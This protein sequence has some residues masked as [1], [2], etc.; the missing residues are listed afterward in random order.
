M[1]ANINSTHTKKWCLNLK[2]NGVFI[3]LFSLTS[4]GDSDDWYLNLDYTFYPQRKP[5]KLDYFKLYFELKKAIKLFN[6][7]ILHSH[8]ATNYSFM[9]AISGFK[10][11]ILTTW[12][13]DVFVYPKKN[14]LFKLLLEFNLY[15]A[16]LVISTSHIMAVELANY[17][18][19][20]IEVI[21]F[22]VDFSLYQ[23]KK[24]SPLSIKT[25]IVLGCFKKTESIYGTDVLIKALSLVKKNITDK[26]IKLMIVGDGKNLEEYKQL[27]VNL[28]L[29][30]DVSFLGWR[31][32]K[33]VPELLS[34]IDICVYLSRNESFGVSLIESMACKI[35]IVASKAPG[36]V[37]VMENENNGL[38]AEIGDE[39][40]AANAIIKLITDDKLNCHIIEHA[41]IHAQKKYD[42]NENIKTQIDLYNRIL[43]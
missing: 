2:K 42:I 30:D 41:F 26:N 3:A 11:H 1:L 36:F 40:S 43:N 8:F 23:A 5:S 31:N 14:F 29:K 35:P 37:E 6:P 17:T 34:K 19:K 10:N 4:I 16:K 25:D 39:K 32:P 21:P 33:D 9:G 28:D 18:G 24:C 38:F 7:D 22:G 20:K 15:K 27:A 12:G 13:S